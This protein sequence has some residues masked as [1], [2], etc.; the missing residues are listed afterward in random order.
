[1]DQFLIR[2][3]FK[4]A[5]PLECNVLQ[6]TF[7]LS[8]RID[9]DD[10]DDDDDDGTAWLLFKCKDALVP[11]SNCDN[12]YSLPVFLTVCIFYIE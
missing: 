11:Q 5:I 2:F 8:L 1:M 10:D 6:S 7:G 3:W 12:K 9:D 4:V